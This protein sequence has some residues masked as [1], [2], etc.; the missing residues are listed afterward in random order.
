MKTDHI[1]LVQLKNKVT[2]A[3]ALVYEPDLILLRS[4]QSVYDMA[5]T[6]INNERNLTELI[7]SALSDEKLSYDEVY[8]GRSD[9]A[10]LPPFD[11]PRTPL[12]CMVS[13]TGLT[14]KNSALN[15]QMM[16][17]TTENKPTDSMVMYQLGVDGGN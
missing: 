15:R 12:F 7:L 16:H 5:M 6:A 8:E 17:N 13:G 14:H 4:F 9:W 1:R 11:H 2:R 10:L 3:V